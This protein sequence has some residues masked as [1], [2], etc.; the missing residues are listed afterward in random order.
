MATLVINRIYFDDEAILSKLDKL[1][2][3]ATM[4]EIHN[5][6]AKFCEPYVPMLS[7]VLSSSGLANV[8][9]DGVTYEAP[10]ARYQYYLHDMNEDLA[11]TTNRTRD[12]HPLATSFWD[13][14][15]IQQRGDEFVEEV[16]K[17]LVR[18]LNG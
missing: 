15:M 11:G 12:F 14:A 13:K 4:L 17:I 6:F 8:Q 7:G 9:P 16:R 1:K 3:D 10:Y 2:D 5:L 18:R